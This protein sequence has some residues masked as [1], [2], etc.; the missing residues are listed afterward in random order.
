MLTRKTQV[1][2]EVEIAQATTAQPASNRSGNAIDSILQSFSPQSVMILLGCAAMMGLFAFLDG[3]GGVKSGSTKKNT[4][5]RAKWAGTKE[6]LTARKLAVKQLNGRSRKS[7]CVWIIRPKN[8]E[9]PD[10]VVKHRKLK[11]GKSRKLAPEIGAVPSKTPVKLGGES[12][13]WKD[14]ECVCK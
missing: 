10:A 9:Y 4:K 13:R 11:S 12:H 8:L 1:S 14:S 6:L 3:K 5:G 7:A 2:Q